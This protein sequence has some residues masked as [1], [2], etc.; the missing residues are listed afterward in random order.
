MPQPLILASTS[1]YRRD[2]LQRLGLPFDAV[3]P[4]VD[5]AEHPGESPAET[6]LRL[7]REKAQA[8]ARRYPQAV[9]I[10]SDQVAEVKGTRLNKPGT[11]EAATLQLGLMSGQRVH[12][13]SALAVVCHAT[14]QVAVDSVPTVVTL[15]SLTPEQIERYLRT[16][17][18]YD[19]A[20]SAKAEGLGITLMAAV[21]SSDPTALIG[22]P[23]IR[24]CDLLRPYGYA[25]P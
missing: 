24:L 7:A 10:G 16:E 23:L 13:H 22:L 11:H 21:E 18:P 8:V 12:F 20:G 1:R 25:L 2:L 15:R 9:V 14:A 19:C 3:A 5:E 6:A 17:E 4:E